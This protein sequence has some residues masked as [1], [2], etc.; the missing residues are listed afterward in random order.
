MINLHSI[1][2]KYIS[3]KASIATL[4]SHLILY[5]GLSLISYG[6]TDSVQKYSFRNVLIAE[7]SI[8]AGSMITLGSVWYSKF[9]HTHWHWFDDSREWMQMDKAGHAFATYQNARLAYEIHR[10]AGFSENQSLLWSASAA[11]IAVSTIELFDGF[12]TDWGAS[13]SDLA[14]NAFG[15]GLFAVQQK[16]F[17]KQVI[18]LKMSYHP[19]NFYKYRPDL[20]GSNAGERIVKDYNAQQYW[21]SVNLHDATT[22][23]FFPKWLNLAVGYGATNMVSAN[24]SNTFV[25]GL[26]PYR[27]FFI[28]PDINFEKINTRSRFLK[29]ALKVLNAIKVPLPAFEI[30]KHHS[31]FWI[32]Y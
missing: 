14:A 23:S 20:L 26:T 12:A 31:K 8:Y 1:T 7:S 17:K 24:T 13:A 2:G 18:A 28:G 5:P 22:L 32:A 3:S 11:F 27:R 19:T 29:G 10:H 6:Q 16:T 4:V 9:D 15:A 21:L 30:N 25:E